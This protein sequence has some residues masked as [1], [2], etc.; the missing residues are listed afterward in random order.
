[1]FHAGVVFANLVWE[2][3]ST[4][5][6]SSAPA[7]LGWF[8]A[9]GRPEASGSPQRCLSEPCQRET[10]GT[11]LGIWLLFPEGPP[12]REMIAN[13]MFIVFSLQTQAATVLSTL[14]SLARL[15][16]RAALAVGVIILPIL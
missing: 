2:R 14:F 11:S 3:F 8:S 15:C 5:V 12:V 16:L 13:V 7:V 10:S 6:P 4:K 1:M 9:R